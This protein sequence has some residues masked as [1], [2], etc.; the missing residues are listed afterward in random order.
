MFTKKTSI[1]QFT[2]KYQKSGRVGQILLKRFFKTIKNILPSDVATVAEIGCGAGYSTKTL[3][4]FFPQTLPFFA[5]D[6]DQDL[7]TLTKLQNPTVTTSVES[8]YTLSHTN[9]S[10][11]IVFCL[12]VLEHLEHPKE[13]LIELARISNKYV[14][15]SVPREPMWRLANMARGAYWKHI[16]NTP[17]H[18]NHWSKRSMQKFVSETLDVVTVT[19]SFPWT[20][21]LAKKHQ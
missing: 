5:S 7:V 15:V 17:G 20:I 19:S 14:V 1:T 4:S 21:I 18:I 9:N 11:D 8:I 2:D 10:F 6:V 13:A 16:G 12:E 3:Q